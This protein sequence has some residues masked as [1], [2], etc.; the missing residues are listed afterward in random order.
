MMLHHTKNHLLYKLLVLV[1]VYLKYADHGEGNWD[2]VIDEFDKFRFYVEMTSEE[3][4]KAWEMNCM[5]FDHIMEDGRCCR[6]YDC[7]YVPPYE[8]IETI[9]ED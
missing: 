2:A 5:S 3:I 9:D 8:D 1:N 7:V 6:E 4:E